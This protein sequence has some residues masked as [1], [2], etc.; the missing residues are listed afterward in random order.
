MQAFQDDLFS[1]FKVIRELISIMNKN[2]YYVFWIRIN[3]KNFRY[4]L[5]VRVK[6]KF[7]TELMI[8]NDP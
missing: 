7:I 8:R 5:I 2:F 4:E 6:W 1:S 3:D